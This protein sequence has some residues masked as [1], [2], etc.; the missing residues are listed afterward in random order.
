MLLGHSELRVTMDFNAHL[1]KQTAAKDRAEDGRCP[2][3]VS[4]QVG[5]QM[6]AAIMASARSEQFSWS[7]W[8]ARAGS[9][10]QHLDESWSRQSD[11]N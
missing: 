8:W 10:A 5:C 2:E 6:A 11:L 7:S 3:A 9:R 1:Q 4:C